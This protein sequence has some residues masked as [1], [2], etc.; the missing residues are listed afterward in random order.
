MKRVFWL[1]L[2]GILFFRLYSPEVLAMSSTNYKIFWDSINIGGDD[3]GSSTNYKLKDTLGDLATGQANSAD[4]SLQAGYRIFDE[5]PILNFSAKAQ[6]NNSQISY[7]AFNNS[8][9]TVTVLSATGYATGDPIVVIE[10]EGANQL[11]ALGQI[12]NI[13]S[14]IIT[15][16]AWEGNNASMS[17]SPLGGDDK[18]YK[19]DSNA[20]SFGTLNS[21]LVKTG[22]SQLEISTNASNGY[23]ITIKENQ[24]LQT[25]NG[26]DINDVADGAVSAGSEEYG[27]KT[28][29]QDAQGSGDWAITGSSQNVAL[30]NSRVNKRRTGI[31]YKVSISSITA[32]GAYSHIVNYYATANF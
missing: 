26:R 22:V 1:L 32:A 4:Y 2:T 7:T 18:V 10:N 25:L 6:D 12:T 21:S 20:I 11:I 24:N 14:D 16:D 5:E 31:I 17:A 27:I 15:V 30:N 19:L 9:K 8:G 29:G 13:A 28:V 23:T 3:A